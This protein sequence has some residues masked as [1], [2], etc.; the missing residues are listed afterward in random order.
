M[1]SATTGGKK[2]YTFLIHWLP[3]PL[4]GIKYVQRGKGKTQKT[5]KAPK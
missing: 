5:F 4:G 3:V 1:N 2:N